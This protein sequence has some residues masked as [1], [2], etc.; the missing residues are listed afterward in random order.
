[1]AN[2]N[3]ILNRPF[4]LNIKIP[5]RTL[6]QVQETAE[7]TIS[8]LWT[9]LFNYFEE[10]NKVF[11]GDVAREIDKYNR[12]TYALGATMREGRVEKTFDT[13]G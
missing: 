12:L 13:K 6:Q 11:T 10:N 9:P 3:N 5:E 2:E 8:G 1:M 4:G 7:E